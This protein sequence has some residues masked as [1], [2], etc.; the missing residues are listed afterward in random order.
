MSGAMRPV[1]LYASM[2]W[3]GTLLP[4][5]LKLLNVGICFLPSKFFSLRVIMVPFQM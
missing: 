2:A 3:T 4:L 1:S 5:L